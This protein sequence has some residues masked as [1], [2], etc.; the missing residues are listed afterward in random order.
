M[1]PSSNQILWKLLQNFVVTIQ[2]YSQNFCLNGRLLLVAGKLAI[3]ILDIIIIS[4]DQLCFLKIKFYQD[5]AILSRI[6]MFGLWPFDPATSQ[7]AVGSTKHPRPGPGPEMQEQG[8]KDNFTP[9]ELGVAAP[10]PC[11]PGPGTQLL[12]KHGSLPSN[13]SITPLQSARLTPHT[14]MAT[15]VPTNS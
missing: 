6:I 8:D 13:I 2:I 1:R 7:A 11:L 3:L 10:L 14:H 15:P 12:N 4:Q 5:S 9:G